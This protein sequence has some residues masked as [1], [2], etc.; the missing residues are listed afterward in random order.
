MKLR[1]SSLYDDDDDHHHQI[2]K[3][4]TTTSHNNNTMMMNTETE[5]DDDN[6]HHLQQQLQQRYQRQN[7]S[8]KI[9]IQHNDEIFNYKNNNYYSDFD[10]INR[11]FNTND[12]EMNTN[13]RRQQQKRPKI[14][15]DDINNRTNTS[16]MNNPHHHHKQLKQTY[17]HHHHH[18]IKD[19]SIKKLLFWPLQTFKMIMQMKPISPI[20]VCPIIIIIMMMKTLINTFS[21]SL[22]TFFYLCKCVVF[23]NAYSHYYLIIIN[24][25]LNY[26]LMKIVNIFIWCHHHTSFDLD[27]RYR[28]QYYLSMLN[29]KSSHHHDHQNHQRKRQFQFSELKN[30]NKYHH[31][32]H[33]NDEIINRRL[34]TKS[35]T[36]MTMITMI[37]ILSFQQLF[38]SSSTMLIM[39]YENG[40]WN[41]MGNK[42]LNHH[43]HHH[44]DD[45]NNNH[46][47]IKRGLFDRYGLFGGSGAGA[48]RS[49]SQQQQQQQQQHQSLSLIGG[50][51]NNGLTSSINRAIDLNY[52]YFEEPN[53]EI[54]FSHMVIN[55]TI[56]FVYIG[57]VNTIYQLNLRLKLLE[58]I[59]MGPYEDSNDCPISKGCAPEVQK[60][61][62]NYYN[63]ALVLDQMHQWL[64]SCGS[65]FQGAC[66]AHS[67]YNI[68]RIIDQ[69]QEPVVANNATASTVAFIAPGP[70]PHKQ[71][72]YVGATYTAGSY[73]S[74]LPVVSSRSLFETS[75]SLLTFIIFYQM[76]LHT[77]KTLLRS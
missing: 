15:H 4:T 49:S 65:L 35:S 9:Q 40:D 1:P 42:C 32:H 27:H 64:I 62:S 13:N 68:S 53:T 6:F 61:L 41:D 69:P 26:L 72:L 60:R 58:K 63:K 11:D 71:V 14:H 2:S 66:T 24:N 43:H 25:N 74:D 10:Q 29:N 21:S 56:G 18:Q 46:T 75:K 16:F 59:T 57:G 47:I 48:D 36:T 70:D 39:A 12:D 22:S 8:P 31:H 17:H 28:Y 50:G 45:D 54:Y 34:Q 30:N 20:T 76:L 23:I 77:K 7:S 3:T 19:R 37:W 52:T 33:H 44:Q 73:R 55:E 67:L 5:E 51:N 38:P